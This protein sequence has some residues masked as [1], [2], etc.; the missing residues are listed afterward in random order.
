MDRPVYKEP[1]TPAE[2]LRLAKE[3]EPLRNTR[4]Y[5]LFLDM[6]EKRYQ[7]LAIECIR[8]PDPTYTREYWQGRCAEVEDIKLILELVQMNAKDAL[9]KMQQEDSPY[10]SSDFPFH[11]GT[12]VL[13]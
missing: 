3:W 7:K 1:T 12:G 6:L 5:I 10:K 13:A 9:A 4:G 8:N 11:S 2:M